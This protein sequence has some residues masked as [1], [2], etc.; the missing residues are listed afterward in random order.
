[1]NFKKNVRIKYNISFFI[2]NRICHVCHQQNGIVGV[3]IL[4]HFPWMETNN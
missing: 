3:S 1:M 2:L 4:Y